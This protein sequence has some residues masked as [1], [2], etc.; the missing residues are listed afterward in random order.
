MAQR[1]SFEESMLQKTKG[2]MQDHF[3]ISDH[4]ESSFIIFSGREAQT[5]Q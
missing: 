3:E 4:H 2:R 5:T 1:D